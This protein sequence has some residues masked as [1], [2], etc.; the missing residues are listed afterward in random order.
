MN[1]RKT[2]TFYL[3]IFGDFYYTIYCYKKQA[4][5]TPNFCVGVYRLSMIY[6]I[7]TVRNLV[8]QTPAVRRLRLPLS[9]CNSIF[10]SL[11]TFLSISVF[12]FYLEMP[13]NRHTF[14]EQN[15]SIVQFVMSLLRK[16]VVY[17]TQ[18]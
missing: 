1:T 17:V 15:R 13:K 2:L 10:Y 9:D 7:K 16:D 6:S 18:N 14:W 8:C 12:I 11:L 5:Y 3:I 4:F